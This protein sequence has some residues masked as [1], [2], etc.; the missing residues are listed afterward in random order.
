M[1]PFLTSENSQSNSLVAEI[2]CVLLEV[3]FALGPIGSQNKHTCLYE[4]DRDNR[5]R[6]QSETHRRIKQ[7]LLP[8]G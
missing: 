6:V 3:T 7:E 2:C 1:P 5:G 8:E 4:E